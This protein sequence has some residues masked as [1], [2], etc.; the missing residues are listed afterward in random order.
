VSYAKDFFVAETDDD[1]DELY[2]ILDAKSSEPGF[3]LC[4]LSQTTMERKF[5]ETVSRAVEERYRGRFEIV[6]KDTICPVT[7]KREESALETQSHADVSFV[8]GD[9]ISSNA[10]KLFKRLANNKP[11]TYFVSNLKE[12]KDLNLDLTKFRTA[13]VVSSSSTPDFIESEIVAY[14]ETFGN[15]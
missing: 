12:L 1:T 15:D 8:V 13:M 11:E 7:D 10:S 3:K 9:R 14:L 2:A 5:F 6:V 4:V